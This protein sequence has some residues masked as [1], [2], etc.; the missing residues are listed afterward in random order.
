MYSVIWYLYVTHKNFLKK[1][2]TIRFGHTIPNSWCHWAEIKPIEIYGLY[3]F[4]VVNAT[5]VNVLEFRSIQVSEKNIN[6]CVFSSV[7]LNIITGVSPHKWRKHFQCKKC[8]R[9]PSARIWTRL[10]HLNESLETYSQFFLWWL[11]GLY[12]FTCQF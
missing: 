11:I 5:E 7:W 6:K 10:Y 9:I 2:L 3:T 4:Y 8:T 1:L 12:K